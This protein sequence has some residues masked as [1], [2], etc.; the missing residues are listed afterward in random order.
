MP[1]GSSV[2][3]SGSPVG[4]TRTFGARSIVG[5]RTMLG[6]ISPRWIV[7]GGIIISA[8]GSQAQAFQIFR[9]RQVQADRLY[10]RLQLHRRCHS[11]RLTWR[12]SLVG[13]PTPN[14]GNVPGGFSTTG[15][16]AF[17]LDFCP[18][19]GAT[20]SLF[21]LQWPFK[22]RGC[23]ALGGMIRV[24]LLQGLRWGRVDSNKRVGQ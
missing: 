14:L 10:G 19:V 7:L 12:S 24:G 5:I 16:A 2:M 3:P 21:L 9:F 6:L 11:L 8:S 15:A 18:W 1:S 20:P 23:S 4:T 22:T 17:W 13:L